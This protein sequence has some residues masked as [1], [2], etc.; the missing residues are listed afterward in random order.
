MDY[1]SLFWGPVV[2]ST[3]DKPWVRL[4]VGHQQSRFLS[5]LTGF[6]DYYIPF[7]CPK[8]IFMVVESKHVL[9]RWSSRL[10]I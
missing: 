7:W 1:Y 2:I 6:V 4:S 3:I 10:A 5:I 9:T 8:A